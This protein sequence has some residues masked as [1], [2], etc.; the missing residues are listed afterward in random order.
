VPLTGLEPATTYQYVAGGGIN[1]NSNIHTFTTLNPEH[2]TPDCTNE[3][4]CGL[5]LLVFADL[6]D[7]NGVTL[8]SLEEEARS[9]GYDLALHAGDFAYNMEQSAALNGDKTPDGTKGDRFMRGVEPLAAR[10]PYMVAPGNHEGAYNFSHYNNRFWMPGG[11]A[12]NPDPNPAANRTVNPSGTARYYS[13]DLPLVHLVSIDT[14]VYYESPEMLETMYNWLE[15][16]LAIASEPKNRADRPWIIVQGHRPLYCSGWGDYTTDCRT[17]LLTRGVKTMNARN[18]TVYQYGLEELFVKAGVDLYLSGHVHN[19]ERMWPVSNYSSP[20]Q[21]YEQPQAPTHLVIGSA[22]CWYGPQNFSP[23]QPEFSAKRINEWGYGRLHVVNRSVLKWEF[24]Q[25][26]Q[27]SATSNVVDSIML[28]QDNHTAFPVVSPQWAL[29]EDRYPACSD[30]QACC[31]PG[32]AG[33]QCH[34]DMLNTVLASGGSMTHDE[35]WYREHCPYT[36]QV[37]ACQ[38]RA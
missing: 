7:A 9:G 37:E 34:G 33:E 13:V 25:V 20:R 35:T 11:D 32:G 31:E 26:D 14:E 8:A 2:T 4:Q 6:G 27:G 15:K 24:V 10:L 38:A 3:E 5:R 30:W 23:W 22:G 18:D 29:C 21:H 36:C 1:G 19:Y 17:T 28:T 12:E 16:D